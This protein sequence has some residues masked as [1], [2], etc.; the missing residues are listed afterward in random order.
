M[1]LVAVANDEQRQIN[2]GWEAENSG[3]CTAGKPRSSDVFRGPP[4]WLISDLHI[5]FI[6]LPTTM[7]PYRIEHVAAGIIDANAE[8]VEM[9]LKSPAVSLVS[10]LPK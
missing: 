10:S 9:Q 2:D 7:S 5:Q 8:L 3:N 1:V 4:P 6:S